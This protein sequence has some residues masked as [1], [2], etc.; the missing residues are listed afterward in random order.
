MACKEQ[1]DVVTIP[2]QPYGLW[3]E[4]REVKSH[5]YVEQDEGDKEGCYDS[6]LPINA[7]ALG[8]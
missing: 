5:C 3:H 2:V 1:I 8:L 4:R 6:K 7:M